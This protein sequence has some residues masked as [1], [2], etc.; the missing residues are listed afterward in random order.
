M[1]DRK[2]DDGE[3][4]SGGTRV[5]GD[6]EEA[7]ALSDRIAALTGSATDAEGAIRVTVNS[8]GI[9]TGLELSDDLRRLTGAD[10]SA[11]IMRAYRRAQA[12]VID[13]VTKA[14][15]DTV[16]A[17]SE[18]G[19]AVLESLAQRFP[20]DPGEPGAPVMPARPPFPTF[21]NKPT[22]PHQ[23]PGNGFESGRDSRAR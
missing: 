3:H 6:P 14:V 8:S 23:Q 12:G 7:A 10:L 15:D 4:R 22:L 20:A 13:Q 5:F 19:R 1:L 2:L 21:K 18:S 9:L 17:D 11:Q 16:G